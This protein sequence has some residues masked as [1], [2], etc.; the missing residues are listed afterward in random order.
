MHTSQ[1]KYVPDAKVCQR[2]GITPMTLW[3]WDN[4]PDL[5]FQPP[6]RVRGRKYRDAAALDAFDAIERP[7]ASRPGR[8]AA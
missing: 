4:D 7:A 8:R 2:Y 3:R 1:K 6:I 5:K